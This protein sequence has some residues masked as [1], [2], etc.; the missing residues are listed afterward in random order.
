MRCDDGD[1]KFV[2]STIICHIYAE[3]GG[4]NDLC[5]PVV[6]VIVVTPAGAC[7]TSPS[8]LVLLPKEKT[9]FSAVLRL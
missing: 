3:R 5:V 8:H 4:V 9:W 1:F 6:T 2:R 7:H